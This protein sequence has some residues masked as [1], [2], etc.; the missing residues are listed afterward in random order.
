MVIDNEIVPDELI[1]QE[2]NVL[3]KMPMQSGDTPLGEPH[4]ASLRPAP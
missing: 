2:L 3:R 4:F 1:E